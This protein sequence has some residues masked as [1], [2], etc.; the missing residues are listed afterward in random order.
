MNI[1]FIQIYDFDLRISQNLN[2]V[3]KNLPNQWIC[4]TDQDTLKFPTFADNLRQ[5]ILNSGVTE[6][7]LLGCMTNRLRPTNPAVINELYDEADINVHF[8]KADALWY[9]YGTDIFK[10]DLVAGCCMVFHKSLWEKVGGFNEDKIFFDKYF[11]KSVIEN[12][13][14]CYIAKGLYIFHLYRWGSASPVDS[15]E[16][17]IKP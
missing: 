4:L 9:E 16:H 3:V 6:N 12:G 17:L 5:I 11:S 1:S 10:A 15:V 2:N 13:G 8:N 14:N 7:D